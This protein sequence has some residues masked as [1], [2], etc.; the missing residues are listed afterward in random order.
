[1]ITAVLMGVTILTGGITMIAI[2][3]MVSDNDNC[4]VVSVGRFA[5]SEMRPLM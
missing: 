2:S 1:M 5:G 3:V 4:E